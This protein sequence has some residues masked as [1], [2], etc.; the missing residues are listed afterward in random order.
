M[1][2]RVRIDRTH[3]RSWAGRD[4]VAGAD[5]GRFPPVAVG[6]CCETCGIRTRREG[7]ESGTRL[8]QIGYRTPRRDGG[9]GSW[10][11]RSYEGGVGNAEWGEQKNRGGGEVIAILSVAKDLG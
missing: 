4:R 11:V 10:E 6:R 2:S 1:V 7:A 8:R 5:R 3:R 9:T